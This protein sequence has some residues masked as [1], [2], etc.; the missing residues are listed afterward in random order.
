MPR[1]ERMAYY[2]RESDESLANSVT[3]ASQAKACV[4]YGEKQN[5]I[6]EIEH[7]YE[8]AISA[9]DVPYT[10]RKRLLAM[11]E[12]A[13][14][15]EFD[16]LVVSEIRALARRQ[17]E[18]LVICDMLR[19]YGVRLETISEKFGEDALS[20]AILSH[21]AQFVEVER[22]QSFLRTERG[23]ADRV[24]IGQAPRNASTVY[25][26]ALVDTEREVKGRYVLNHEVVFIDEDGKQ[27]SRVEVAVFFCD[28]LA[29]GGSLHGTARILNDMGIPSPRG[30]QWSPVALQGIVEN[31]ILYGGVYANRYKQ[32]RRGSQKMASD[33]ARWS[34]AP[35]KS[36]FASPMHQQ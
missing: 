11:L 32:V 22:E 8:E 4:E 15:G 34:F 20:K 2:V 19:R 36:G 3:M 31:P 26:H 23:K 13:R 29:R 21:R 33:R 25:T 16:V 1:R 28:L 14:R 24:A 35:K 5:Y 9:Y 6:L 18:V 27:W 12:A 30:K 7:R 17:V 10:R